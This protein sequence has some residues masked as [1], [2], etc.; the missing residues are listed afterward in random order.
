MG[1]FHGVPPRVRVSVARW[2]AGMQFLSAFPEGQLLENDRLEDLDEEWFENEMGELL[3]DG[4]EE[5]EER[6]G[7]DFVE[8]CLQKME[9]TEA[10]TLPEAFEMLKLVK[11]GDRR[12][13]TRLPVRPTASPFAPAEGRTYI[14]SRQF[15]DRPAGNGKAGVEGRT[16][17]PVAFQSVHNSELWFSGRQRD[18]GLGVASRPMGRSARD[19]KRAT[20]GAAG[21]TV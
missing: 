3:G 13:L 2:V 9:F 17:V 20:S 1:C 15:A 19:G 11:A 8:S 12:L 6:K 14:V 5:D 7:V 4:I 21:R 10:L 18:G 16:A